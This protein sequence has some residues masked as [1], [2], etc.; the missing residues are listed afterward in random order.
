MTCPLVGRDV[1]F[2]VRKCA[3]RGQKHSPEAFLGP[4]LRFTV[5]ETS[6]LPSAM[7]KADYTPFIKTGSALHWNLFPAG[8]V[9]AMSSDV[10]L[11]GDTE[12]SSNYARDGG[13]PIT[14][15]TDISA[16]PPYVEQ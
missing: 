2:I 8:A 11:H 13:K 3:L 16:M 6:L 12:F 15:C 4:R 1:L 10:S 5:A 9:Y 14:T 7:I